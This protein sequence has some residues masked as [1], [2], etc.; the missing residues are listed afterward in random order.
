[1]KLRVKRRALL[2]VMPW[3]LLAHASGGHARPVVMPVVGYLSASSAASSESV[4]PVFRQGLKESGY[5]EGRNV[6][7]EFRWADGRYDLLPGFAQELVARKVT[8]LVA[9]GGPAARAAR[10]AT[11]SIPIVFQS[12][13][14]PVRFGLVESLARPGGNATGISLNLV[15]L[16][17][18]RLEL[19]RELVPK[20]NSV[21]Y[22]TNPGLEGTPV[23]L[24]EVQKAAQAM[25]L[26]LHVEEARAAEDIEP[27]FARMARLRP[28]ALLVG[29]SILFVVQ[30]DQVVA[31]AA[32]HAMPAIYELSHY[33]TQGGLISYGPAVLEAVRPI[34][35][36]TG[37]I[38]AGAKPADLPVQQP[39]KFELVINATTA[40]VLGLTLSP[41][42][43]ARADAVVE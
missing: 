13:G 12:G 24:S 5:V 18:K 29:S 34:G 17:P 8:V 40:K 10:Q 26:A 2:A 7:I 31:L 39:S 41:A 43:L 36:Y 15:G 16:T 32:R 6:A 28:S 37:R 27:A 25:G 20:L 9:I 23:E 38:L 42:M 14:D 11:S 21:A 4:L 30:R 22:L 3:P 35:V 33:V 19:L 1:M